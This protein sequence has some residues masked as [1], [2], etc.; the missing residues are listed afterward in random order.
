M[1]TCLSLGKA[2][3]PGAALVAA[4]MAQTACRKT[5]APSAPA[6]EEGIAASGQWAGHTVRTAGERKRPTQVVILLHGWGAP[7]DDLVS[8]SQ[9]LPAP[10]RLF[11]FP[12]APLVSPGGGGAW[13]HL[14]I[15]RLIAARERGQERDLRNEVPEGLAEARAGM[16]A[17]VAEV[18]KRT[19]L[20]ASAIVLGGFSQGA[21]LAT[22]VALS[23]PE[24]PAAVVAL[25]GTLLAEAQWQAW[26]DKLNQPMPV[27][28]SHGLHDPILPFHLSEA[29]R[30]RLQAAKQPVTWVP[31]SGGHEIPREVLAKLARFLDENGRATQ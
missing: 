1:N 31:F 30:D 24:H 23:L 2:T 12:A 19:Q 10:G 3:A 17:L 16:A 22:D 29:L 20:P 27:F 5:M 15:N 7:G 21:M 28:L 25:S 26:I 6:S 9:V 14:D 13:W 18:Q 11:V 8:L 4:L